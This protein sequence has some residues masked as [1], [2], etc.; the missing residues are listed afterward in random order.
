MKDIFGREV[1]TLH[2]AG[3]GLDIQLN[4]EHSGLYFIHSQLENGD[5]K[6]N[7]VIVNK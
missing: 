3:N 5:S 7:K 1:N 2:Q 4:L 6:V